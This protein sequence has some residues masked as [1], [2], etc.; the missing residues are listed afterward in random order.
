MLPFHSLRPLNEYTPKEPAHTT[1]RCVIL[2]NLSQLRSKKEKRV[3]SESPGEKE[4]THGPVAGPVPHAPTHCA[5][6]TYRERR[7]GSRS[8]CL[9]VRMSDRNLYL[10]TYS[11]SVHVANK[12]V[13]HLKNVATRFSMFSK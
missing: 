8:Q 7:F 12:N 10:P 4:C 5:G 2:N 3:E 9:E 1:I 11:V 6:V 13:M